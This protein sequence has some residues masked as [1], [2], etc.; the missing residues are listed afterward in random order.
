MIAPH[1][2]EPPSRRRPGPI[3][4]MGTGFR[5]CGKT[6][7]GRLEGTDI[8]RLNVALALVMRLAD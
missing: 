1:A 4:N 6:R 7:I 5:R 3:P 2:D 8:A